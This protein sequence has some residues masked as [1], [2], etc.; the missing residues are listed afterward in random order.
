M[1]FVGRLVT[2]NLFWEL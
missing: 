1:K 2:S